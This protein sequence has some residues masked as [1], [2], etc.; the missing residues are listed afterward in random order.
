MWRFE[1]GVPVEAVTR[2]SSLGG[3]ATHDA[4]TASSVPEYAFRLTV[5]RRAAR[6]DECGV[7]RAVCGRLGA[8]AVLE[9]LGGRSSRLFRSGIQRQ[10]GPST[11][12]LV[13]TPAHGHRLA[14]NCLIRPECLPGPQAAARHRPGRNGV[15]GG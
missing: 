15:A 5:S 2:R 1:A 7:G 13:P 6:V 8:E 10:A 12:P 14:I 9:G 4:V 3:P 11:T